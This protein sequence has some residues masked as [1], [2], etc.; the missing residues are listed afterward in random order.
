MRQLPKLSARKESRKEIIQISDEVDASLPRHEYQ[1]NAGNALSLEEVDAKWAKRSQQSIIHHLKKAIEYQE[2]SQEKE[3]PLT[4][5]DAAYKKLT[6]EKMK[7]DSIALADLPQAR[8]L[9]SDIQKKAKEI[10][11]EI[12]HYQKEMQDLSRKK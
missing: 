5:L 4:L 12:Y 7:V 3:T 1:D 6:H 11:G 10:E 8:Q 2:S 9:T